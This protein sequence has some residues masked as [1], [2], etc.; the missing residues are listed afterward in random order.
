MYLRFGTWSVKS[1]Y[2]SGS[3][4][5]ISG[6]KAK[7]K[8]HL[9]G[10]QVRWDKGGTEPADDYI[11]FYGNENADHHLGTGFFFFY[12]RESYQQLR[13]LRLLAIGCHIQY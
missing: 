4:K 8:L 5:L 9:V 1:L 6:E 11:F 7:H 10:V 13:G 3:L 2:R 12:T